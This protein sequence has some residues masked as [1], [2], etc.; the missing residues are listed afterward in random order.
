MGLCVGILFGIYSNVTSCHA[1][2]GGSS[3]CANQLQSLIAVAEFLLSIPLILLFSWI[4]GFQNSMLIFRVIVSISPV[5][6]LG[7]VGSFAGY[8]I[9]KIYAK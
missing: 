1:S 7:I 8:I 3:G 4:P 9:D 6:F 5:L 2:F